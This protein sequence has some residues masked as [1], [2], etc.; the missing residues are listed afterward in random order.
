MKSEKTL[1]AKAV[2][3]NRARAWTGTLLATSALM[4]VAQISGAA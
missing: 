3:H 2:S 1:L 4:L